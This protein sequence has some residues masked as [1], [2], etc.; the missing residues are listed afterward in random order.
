MHLLSEGHK[1]IEE[2]LDIKPQKEILKRLI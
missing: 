1:F 2:L